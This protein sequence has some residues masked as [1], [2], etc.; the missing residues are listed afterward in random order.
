MGRTGTVVGL[1]AAALAG[2][3]AL[4]WAAL[5]QVEAPCPAALGPDVDCF[6]GQSYRGAFYWIAKPR[7][8]NGILVVHAHGGPRLRAPKADDPVE[9][10]KRFAVMVREGYAW[11]GSSYRRGG[12]GV[13]MAA[14]DTDRLRRIFIDEFGKPRLTF[15]HGQSWGGNIVAKLIEL[16]RTDPDGSRAYDGALLTSGVLAGG[17]RAYLFR[18]DL[19]AVYG[20]Y[21]RNH[22]RPDEDRYPVWMGLPPG[23]DL[24]LRDLEA[25][26]D[27]CTGARRRPE[28]R[29]PQQAQN[30]ANITRVIRIP[31]SS[32][33]SHLDW[34]TFLFRDLVDKR[35]DGDN[36]FGNEGVRYSGSHDDAA[37]NAGVERFAADPDAVHQLAEDA[38]PTGDVPIPVVTLHAIEDPTAFVEHESAYRETLEK[39]GKA[40]NLVQVF[41][42]ESLHSALP[43]PEYATA[44]D[45]LRRWVET[46]SR[47]SAATIAAA[48]PVFAARLGGACLFRPDYTPPPFFSRTYPR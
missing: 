42:G 7:S 45:A 35:L 31:E 39:A 28:E 37:L 30:L 29:T 40:H 3:L 34:A 46:G 36:P 48:C 14:R 13:T 43:D 6:S 23:S 18:A 22:P 16:V 20:F 1:L 38:D 4:P 25:R 26:I 11:A 41:T 10:L 19:R 2:A 21:C 24:S 44:L 32:L 12:Y 47:P 9:D 33:I 8:W 17:T 27:A 15:A 5:A